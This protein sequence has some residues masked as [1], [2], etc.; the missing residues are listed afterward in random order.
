MKKLLLIRHAKAT[1]D[2]GYTDFE[3]PLTAKGLAQ[4]DVMVNRLVANDI[5]PEHIVSSPA[6]RTVT[7]A[8]AFAKGLGLPTAT[9]YHEIYDASESALLNVVYHLDNQYDFI[10]LVGHN[11][12]ISQV[13]YYLSGEYR[14]V[15]TCALALIEFDAESWAEL[16]ENTGTLTYFDSPK[17]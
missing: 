11:P 2:T 17:D 1:H 4:C 6:L 10:A 12:G 9:Y 3:R 8:D 16:S 13:L 7:T 5:Q 15:T 14:E